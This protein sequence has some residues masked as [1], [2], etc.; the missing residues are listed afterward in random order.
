MAIDASLA[1]LCDFAALARWMDAQG[2][3]GGELDEVSPIAGGTQNVLLRFR[4]GGREYVLRRPPLHPRPK[5]NDAL[6]REG[7]VLAALA[8]SPVPHPRF[9]AGCFDASLMGGYVFYLMEPVEGFNPMTGLLPLHAGDARVRH[10]MGLEAADAIAHLARVDPLAVGLAQL[11]R[12]EGFLERQVTRWLSELESYSRHA[13]YPG[14]DIPGLAEVAAWL[15]RNRPPLSRAG[16][17]H[18]D[19]HL[20]NVMY[21]RDSARLAAVVDW[22]MCTLGD[23]LLD[24]GWLIATWPEREGFA[25]GPMA[26][27]AAL[28]GWPTPEE[29]AARYA[30]TSGHDV[31]ALPWYVVLASFK[32]GIVLEGTHARAFAGKAPKAMGDFLHAVTLALFRRARERIAAA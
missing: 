13:G 2:L 28:D 1:G 3:P 20:A 32:L 14:P 12:P 25:I 4:R 26:A 10:A 23:P 5:S 9:I 21:A 24:L 19:Y 29:L 7:Q 11:G 17:L 16:I 27:L 8:G 18:G 31:T 15:E 22:E 6:R 30:A